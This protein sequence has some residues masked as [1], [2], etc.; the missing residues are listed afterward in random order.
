MYSRLS[1]FFEIA[2]VLTERWAKKIIFVSEISPGFSQVTDRDNIITINHITR[3]NSI[4]DIIHN[5]KYIHNI[6][7]T[8]IIIDQRIIYKNGNYYDL[9]T[10]TKLKT[11]VSGHPYDRK[12]FLMYYLSTNVDVIYYNKTVIFPDGNVKGASVAFEFN[13]RELCF[14]YTDRVVSGKNYHAPI[15][16]SYTISDETIIVGEKEF[17]LPDTVKYESIEIYKCDGQYVVVYGNGLRFYEHQLNC[18]EM[19]KSNAEILKLKI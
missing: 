6:K 1:N 13:G 17:Y 19:G 9:D 16:V 18:G 8:T 2:S 14:A 15:P 5:G 3:P 12:L 11:D 7:P 4:A 10:F